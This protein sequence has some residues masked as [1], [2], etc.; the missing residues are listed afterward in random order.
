MVSA[1][2]PKSD[3]L[4]HKLLQ[5]RLA[6]GLSQDGMLERLGLAEKYFRSRI[7]AYEL[8]D[9]EPHLPTLLLYARSVGISTD[10]LIDDDKDLPAKLRKAAQQSAVRSKAVSRRKRK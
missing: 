7:S 3:R 8:G 10:V 4:G 6:L 1:R 2:N 9:R 5:I